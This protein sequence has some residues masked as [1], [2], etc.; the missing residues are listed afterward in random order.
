MTSFNILAKYTTPYSQVFDTTIWSLV[1]QHKC[2]I[3][4]LFF[5]LLKSFIGEKLFKKK[6]K[7]STD[8]NDFSDDIL[9]FTG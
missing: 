5:H 4:F 1:I 9:A 3:V 8:F 7:C 6:S 2:E